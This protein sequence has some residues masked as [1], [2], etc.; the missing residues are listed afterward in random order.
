MDYVKIGSRIR[1]KRKEIGL[2][3]EKLSEFANLSPSFLSGIELGRKPGAFDTYLRIAKVLN[4]SLDYLTQDVIPAAR[5]NVDH[6]ELI[7][8]FDKLSYKQQ[9]YV[10]EAL[11]KFCD[12]VNN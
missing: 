1:N 8:N 4:V 6:E 10:L 9:R 3:Q 2:S 11:Q 5:A 7:K 12:F